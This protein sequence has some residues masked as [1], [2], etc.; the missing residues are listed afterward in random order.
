M[1][2]LQDTRISLLPTIQMR[3]IFRKS[4]C[5]CFTQ[6]YLAHVED[7]APARGSCWAD[8]GEAISDFTFDGVNR[9]VKSSALPNNWGIEKGIYSIS[10]LITEVSDIDIIKTVVSRGILGSNYASYL[11]QRDEK[12]DH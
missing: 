7:G 4:L 6:S 2:N 11:I 3:C 5:F 8:G 12:K 9:A 1:G 10:D